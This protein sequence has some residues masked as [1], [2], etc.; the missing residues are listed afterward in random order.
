MRSTLVA[1]SLLAAA[2]C[3]GGD[4]LSPAVVSSGAPDIVD[5]ASF[6]SG[7]DNFNDGGSQ[8]PQGN[9]R[10]PSNAFDGSI[11]VKR[12]LGVGAETGG[13]FHYPFYFPFQPYPG[14]TKDRIW[15][16][17]YF[18]IDARFDGILKLQLFNT[19]DGEDLGGLFLNAGTIAWLPVEWLYAGGTIYNLVPLDS[20]LNGWHSLE[21]DFWRNGDPSGFSSAAIW[22]DSTQITRTDGPIAESGSAN[23]YWADNRIQ[24]GIR[25]VAH[26]GTHGIGDVY[27]SGIK[28][29]GN[30]VAANLWTDRVA[31]SSN[32]P[33]GP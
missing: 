28:N 33:I 22:L 14:V 10:D 20:L 23:G 21:V 3:S 9:A 11:G 24:T 4:H 18:Y 1:L 12:V 27:W 31:I 6:E 8:A 13:A 26:T 16:R 19:D 15:T 17:F 7:W 5:N 2:A 25:D 32:G 29:A 30:T